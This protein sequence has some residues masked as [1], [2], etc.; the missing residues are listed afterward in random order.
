MS[1]THWDPILE[2]EQ[3]FDRYRDHNTRLPDK[4]RHDEL[5]AADWFP[6]VDIAET[7]EAFEIHAELPGIEKPDIR[8]AVQDGVI[9]VK[10]HR[11]S[12]SEEKGKKFHRVER[13]FG[14]FARSFSLPDN[15]D[16]EHIHADFKKGILTLILPK[17]QKQEP[18]SIEVKL[19]D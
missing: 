2:L 16:E 17:T 10:G 1:L 13:S 19:K 6:K 3:F 12:K 15:V 14:S 8:I 5:A 11:E 18:K 9:T 4:R 7:N